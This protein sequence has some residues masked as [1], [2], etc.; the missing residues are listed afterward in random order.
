MP[1]HQY[2]RHALCCAYQIQD[3]LRQSHLA[4]LQDHARWAVPV[5]QQFTQLVRTSALLARAVSRSP[6]S[7]TARMV[8]QRL[9]HQLRSTTRDMQTLEHQLTTDSCPPIPPLRDLL[10]ELDQIESEF[11]GWIYDHLAKELSTTTEPISLEGIALGPFK[12]RL[13]L[14]QTITHLLGRLCWVQALEPNPATGNSEVTHPHVS[15]EA[16]C[17]GDAGP[18]LIRALRSGRVCDFFL[19]IRGVLENYNPNSPYVRLDEWSGEPCS[20]CGQSTHE[21]NRSSCE[22]CDR[23]VCDECISSCPHC[24]KTICFGCVTQCRSCEQTSCAQCLAPCASCGDQVCADCLDNDLCPT[25]LENQHDDD[26]DIN[27]ESTNDTQE[28]PEEENATA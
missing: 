28:S 24:D 10:G 4:L 7:R 13:R 14:G 15:G 3:T 20:D 27:N 18:D 19:L 21:D 5:M 8:D 1:R 17:V 12:I 26:D 2:D 11:G 16:V 9:V 25:C 6:T 23:S 22:A